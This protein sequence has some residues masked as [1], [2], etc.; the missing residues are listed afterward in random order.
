MTRERKDF[1]T[2]R[3][4]ARKDDPEKSKTDE[5]PDPSKHSSDADFRRNKDGLYGGR[6]ERRQDEQAGAKRPA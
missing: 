6:P 4:D 1:G 5:Q 3:E 2:I